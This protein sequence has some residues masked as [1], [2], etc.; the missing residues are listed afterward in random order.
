MSAIDNAPYFQVQEEYEETLEDPDWAAELMEDLEFIAEGKIPP[1]L[2]DLPGFAE[3][4][5]SFDSTVNESST[6]SVWDRL[7]NPDNFTGTQK[8][9]KKHLKTKKPHFHG[10]RTASSPASGSCPRVTTSGVGPTSELSS[11]PANSTQVVDDFPGP[12]TEGK[13]YKSVFDRL[14]SPSQA[15]GTQRQRLAR[16]NESGDLVGQSEEGNFDRLLDDALGDTGKSEPLH[17]TERPHDVEEPHA[18]LSP[19]SKEKRSVGGHY[20]DYAEQDVFERLQR[21]STVSSQNR[22]GS[23][24]SEVGS[25]ESM[26]VLPQASQQKCDQVHVTANMDSVEVQSQTNISNHHYH[27]DTY[28]SLDV[29]ERLQKTTT[30]AYAKKVNKP[31]D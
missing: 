15:T 14:I 20:T 29:F 13:M 12:A 19:V 23:N 16:K 9:K 2:Q 1:S 7:T 28:T 27:D 6:G 26:K 31:R 8:R 22:L 18:I 4:V 5:A 3:Q 25:T 21:T 10:H 30:E 24:V 11:T 17:H